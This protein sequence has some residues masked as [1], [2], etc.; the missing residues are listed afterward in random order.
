MQGHHA[1]TYT[2]TQSGK[3]DPVRTFRRR[4]FTMNS[5]ARCGAGAGS[6][7]RSTMLLSNGSPG[8]TAQW[9]K[10]DR[11]NA[12]PCVWYLRSRYKASKYLNIVD[13]L[14]EARRGHEEC[15]VGHPASSWDELAATTHEWLRCNLG[16]QNLDLDIADGFIAKWALACAPLEAGHDAVLDRVKQTLINLAWQRVVQQNIRTLNHR[17]Q[18]MVASKHLSDDVSTTVS[19]KDTTGSATCGWQPPHDQLQ[20]K[21]RPAFYAHLDLNLSIEVAKVL[22]DGVEEELA[23]AEDGVLAGL[24]DARHGQRRLGGRLHHAGGVEA[25]RAD[26]VRILGIHVGCADDGGGLVDGHIDALEQHPGPGGPLGNGQAVARLQQPEAGHLLGRAVLLV[27]AR[28]VALAKNTHGLPHAH[29]AA[30]HASE[31]VER[32]AVR[33]GV[34]LGNVHHER[35]LWV[36]LCDAARCSAVLRPRVEVLCLGA[37]RVARTRQVPDEH[38]AQLRQRR[39]HALPVLPDDLRVD[40]V[41]RLEHEL[42]ERALA[43]LGRR[44][45]AEGAGVGVVVDIAPELAR[46]ALRVQRNAVDVAVQLGK[47]GEREGPAGG[48][49][50]EGHV[51]RGGFERR[52][53]AAAVRGQQ[54]VEL[55]QRVPQLVV[56]VGRRQFELGDEAVHL[57]DDGDDGQALLQR[58]LDGAL[59]ADHGALDSV[60]DQQ[61]AV[62][63]AYGGAELVGEVGVAG[64]VHEVDEKVLAG[65]VGQ[66]QR[67]RR[68]LDAY[69]A[70]LLVQ[71]R[72]SEAQVAL[73]A[74][75][76]RAQA[77]PPA[78]A[79]G[80]PASSRLART[81]FTI[82]SSS[83]CASSSSTSASTPPP[84]TSSAVG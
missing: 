62:G 45:A 5:R 29:R 79:G 48:G 28:R 10:T 11:Q 67:Q 15:R 38:V 84:Y 4:V 43:A 61:E 56:G 3:G 66:R 63:E 82:G 20:T 30:Q 81:G 6:R 19:Q 59:R 47:G 64:R 78:A 70:L 49:A 46:E 33:L 25:Q 21:R 50:G 55:L 35:A 69:A 34:Q 7:G 26:D 68:G 36:A 12:W 16:I 18:V 17:H 65:A 83:A 58:V 53:L 39:L 72:V 32:A 40:L 41:Q 74:G 51:A 9:S 57:V 77:R 27:L 8:T 37:P 42:D 23:G 31:R 44:L 75:V 22:H 60:D 24:L 14:H 52:G 73:G 13:R 76:Q 2:E 71:A 80:G 54:H 1:W